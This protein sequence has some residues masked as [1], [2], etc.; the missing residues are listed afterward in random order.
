MLR[1]YF[2]LSIKAISRKFGWQSLRRLGSIRIFRL[3]YYWLILVPIFAKLLSG[4]SSAIT[5]EIF[6]G[7]INLN[8]GLPF[9]WQMLYFSAVS[10]SI[11][12]I[13]YQINCPMIISRYTIYSEF[14]AEGRGRRNLMAEL[15]KA[16]FEEK[17]VEEIDVSNFLDHFADYGTRP[18][19]LDPFSLKK[20]PIS[21]RDLSEAFWD[22]TRIYIRFNYIE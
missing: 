9:S 16:Y 7:R 8:I 12:T 5:F 13:I 2:D 15:S 22:C 17:L 1:Y 6:G 18:N 19:S 21:S 20:T 3:W 10:F 14:A 4:L 11:A